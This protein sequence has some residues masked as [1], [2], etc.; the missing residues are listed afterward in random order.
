MPARERPCDRGAP[1][2]PDDMDRA[3]AEPLDQRDDV[4]DE[5]RH[6]VRADAAGAGERRVAALVRRDRAIA[7]GIQPRRDAR[8]AL[9]RLRPAVQ[10]HDDLAVE[11]ARID[12]VESQSI[13]VERGDAARFIQ[14][15]FS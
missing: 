2:V 8:P 1:V 10:Q 12:G 5:M 14:G 7:V 9:R 15:R 11:R 4:A 6:P 3:A 13:V